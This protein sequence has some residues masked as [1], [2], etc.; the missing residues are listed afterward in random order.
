MSEGILG[1]STCNNESNM[2]GDTIINY[3]VGTC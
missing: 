3:V 1:C 2:A